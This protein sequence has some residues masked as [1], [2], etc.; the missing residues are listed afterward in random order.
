VPE[1]LFGHVRG[2]PEGSRFESR[3]ELSE[4][5]VH[6]PT[7]AGIS[8]SEREGAD[9]IVLSGGYEDEIRRA[10]GRSRIRV[11]PV[12][13]GRLPTAASTVS[14][15]GSFGA[16]GITR[17][18]PPAR[19]TATTGSTWWTTTGTNPEDPAFEFGATGLSSCRIGQ[20]RVGRR[21]RALRAP[22]PPRGKRRP[23]C[24]SVVRPKP[25][26]VEPTTFGATICRILFL[27]VA[28]RCRNRLSKLFSLLVVARSFYMLRARWC[29]WW[30]QEA[31]RYDCGDCRFPS[32]EGAGLEPA[33]PSL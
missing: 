10:D 23:C 4:A 22:P 26:R 33:T 15:Y 16:R 1:R 31:L 8:G 28:A 13:T 25:I 18:T 6:R 29:Q 12:G 2:Y 5:G 21:R 9:S 27:G 20:A 19:A 14:R 30:C 3:A 7:V 11:S 17:R 24:A 32:V